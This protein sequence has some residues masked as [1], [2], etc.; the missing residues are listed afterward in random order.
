MLDSSMCAAITAL[1]RY[2]ITFFFLLVLVAVA[3]AAA[4]DWNLLLNGKTFHINAPAGN[5][6]N[7]KNWGI[8]LHYDMPQ[9]ESPWV[10]FV[11]A[12]QFRDSNENI[13]YY[14]GGGF[15]RRWYP[16][17]ALPKTHVDLGIVAFL[18]RREGFHDGNWFPGMLPVL[19]IGGETVALNMTYIP[20][21]DPKM[22]PLLFLQL[23]LR[24]P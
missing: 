9:P 13:S 3:P 23:K 15:A 19:S 17:T 24:L 10:R 20:K 18:M 6:Y 21:V 14:A 4:G 12:S 11:N 2:P 7:E 1:R 22:V 8:G 5:H 16:V